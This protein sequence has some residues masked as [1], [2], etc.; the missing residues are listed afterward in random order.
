MLAWP[1]CSPPPAPRSQ[2]RKWIRNLEAETQPE[3][4]KPKKAKE[5]AAAS[6]PKPQTPNAEPKPKKR[7]TTPAAPAPPPPEA[8]EPDDEETRV[9]LQ[10]A[11]A[12][13]GLRT[14]RRAAAAARLRVQVDADAAGREDEE[15]EED[16]SAET[17]GDDDDDYDDGDGSDDAT[18]EMMDES[19]LDVGDGSA[20]GGSM[21]GSPPVTPQAPE[22]FSAA[23]DARRAA[24]RASSSRTPDKVL[25]GAVGSPTSPL[26]MNDPIIRRAASSRPR[27]LLSLGARAG[28]QPPVATST[29]TP[30]FLLG[31]GGPASQWFLP[32]DGGASGLG[33]VGGLCVVG[34]LGGLGGAA[35][36]INVSP[37]GWVDEWLSEVASDAASELGA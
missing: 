16:P 26:Q 1:G 6:R 8:S 2:L 34:G 29:G 32:V 21:R 30:L 33:V 20:A 17:D 36:G 22:P 15:D 9:Q 10:A 25:G 12:S 28:G 14:P 24:R 5:G 37:Q 27:S 19:E 31:R 18:D 35:D 11:A 23:A 4:A 7:K 3:G 13:A